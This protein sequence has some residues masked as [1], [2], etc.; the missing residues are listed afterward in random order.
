MS[1]RLALW[2]AKRNHGISEPEHK[3][4][5]TLPLLLAGPFGLLM[6]GMGAY[7]ELHWI[8]FV[9]GIVSLCQPNISIY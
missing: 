5:L 1:D 3:L 6:M 9:I 7:F 2:F 4:W 8:V